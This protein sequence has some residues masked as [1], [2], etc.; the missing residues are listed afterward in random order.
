MNQ[1]NVNRAASMVTAANS[2]I[3]TLM[4][5]NPYNRMAV[6]AF[7]SYNYGG[8]TSN[9]AAA[10]V[11]SSL[12]HYEGEEA[13]SH[14]RWATESGST[15]GWGD[16]DYIA[17]CDTVTKT[18]NWNQT[19]TQPATRNG[20]SGGTNIQAGIVEG[21]K[22]L[23]ANSNTT[24][25]QTEYGTVTRMPF[26][27]VLSDGQPTF[28][29]QDSTWYNPTS[30][31][32]LG[33]GKD[34]FAGN[35]FLPALTAAYYKAKITEK[36]YGSAASEKNR[37]S[38]YTV[39]VQLT[40]E[41]AKITLSA[42]FTRLACA[43]TSTRGNEIAEVN[44]DEDGNI[45]FAPI[46]LEAAGEYTLSVKEVAVEEEG[47]T[48]DDTVFT[49]KITVTNTDGV[50]NAEVEYVDGEIVFEN[51]YDAPIEPTESKKPGSP[52]TGDRSQ[53]ALFSVLLVMGLSGMAEMII[54]PKRKKED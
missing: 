1:N 32:E 26:I 6:V 50:L 25:V 42:W 14:L 47:L 38:I 41:L 24:T 43:A 3:A 9:K 52:D 4:D 15:T 30:T 37:C 11:L 44:N 22:L 54:L 16:K 35:G 18:S 20:Y 46:P 51:T 28:S 21:A 31:T 39:G 2:A 29:L 49:V 36:Y 7:S 10:N 40:E 27:M 13:T 8:G 23:T 45:A 48:C 17:G 53:L 12:K 19:T 34:P 33:D 5:A